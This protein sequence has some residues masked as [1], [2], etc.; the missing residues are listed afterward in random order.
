MIQPLPSVVA[1]VLQLVETSLTVT[2]LASR[3]NDQL[4]FVL[5]TGC[6]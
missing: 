5:H 1:N 4:D 2:I 6:N 3:V